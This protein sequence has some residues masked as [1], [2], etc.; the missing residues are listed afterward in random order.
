M[1]QDGVGYDEW[2]IDL[3][4]TLARLAVC[5]ISAAEIHVIVPAQVQWQVFTAWSRH[6]DLTIE[7][8]DVEQFARSVGTIA[9]CGKNLGIQQDVCTALSRVGKSWDGSADG[10]RG[11]R[12]YDYKG[13][14]LD[15]SEGPCPAMWSPGELSLGQVL[16][17]LVCMCGACLD[18]LIRKGKLSPMS[19][20]SLKLAQG[21]DTH[22][23][24]DR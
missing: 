5:C 13:G 2:P 17:Q 12:M 21:D 10:Y 11:R 3:T 6:G 1:V 22:R 20:F 4:G 7:F 19:E 24:L 16:R 14:G 9:L 18:C 8:E 15:I 23:Y